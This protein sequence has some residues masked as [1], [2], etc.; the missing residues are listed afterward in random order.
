[1]EGYLSLIIALVGLVLYFIA[2]NPKVSECGRILFWT[3]LLA[4]LL[5]NGGHSVGLLR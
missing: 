1:M 4:F 2:S 5:T 3:G